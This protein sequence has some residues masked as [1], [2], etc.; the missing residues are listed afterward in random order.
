[1][2]KTAVSYR[3][4]LF[5]SIVFL[6]SA[7]AA[8]AQSI[9]NYSFSQS[10][11][12]YI[13][14]TGATNAT[15]LVGSLDDGLYQNIPI[16]FDFW[17]MGNRFTSISAG[18]NGFLSF[19]LINTGDN[20]HV[21]NNLAT[22][23]QRNVLAPLWDDLALNTTTAVSYFLT[24]AVGSRTFTIQYTNVKWRF[25]AAVNM[26]F[27]VRLY[28]ANGEIEYNYSPPNATAA[29]AAS[30]SIGISAANG[31]F[32][33]LNATTNTAAASSAAETTTLS[34]KPA[35]NQRYSFIPVSPN[36][37]T[38]AVYSAIS[39]TSMTLNWTD[40]ANDN[41]YVIYRSTDGTNYN[42]ELTT[43][44]NANSYTATNL[45][46]NTTYYW[47][48]Y[49]LR[50]SLSNGFLQFPAQSTSFL[51]AYPFTGNAN[52]VGGSNNNGT[53]QGTNGGAASLTNDRY[54]S[55]N[56]AYQFD[57]I[58]DNITTT[59]AMAGPQVFSISI[60]FRTS[61]AG[62]KLIGFGGNQ[63]GSSGSYDRHIYMDNAGKVYFGVYPGQTKTLNSSASLN[64]NV[65]HNAIATLSS[66]GMKLYI[67]GVLQG[68]DATVT[69]AQ[70]YTGYWRIGY[71]NTNGWPSTPTN[72]YF[73]GALDD[74]Q[75]TNYE[76]SN[77]EIASLS[78][79]AYR[80]Y[81]YTLPVTL[82][83][84]S[85]VS[86]TQTN[87]PYLI[88]I[89]DD[90][91]KQVGSCDLTVSNPVFGKVTS[92]VGNDIAFTDE[93]GAALSFDVEQY[94][95]AT[96]SLLAWVKLPYVSSTINKK[97]NILIGNPSATANNSS[98]TWSTDYK[99]VFHFKES[100]YSGTTTDATSTA[101]VGT[102]VGMTSA[103]LV[104]TGKVGNA[105][106]YNGSTQQINVAANAVYAI[107]G[108]AYT[109]SA[110]IN[111]GST[112]PDQKVVTNQEI[113][114][115]ADVVP[116]DP[117][118]GGYKIGLYNL[119]PESENRVA[120]GITYSNRQTY[121][122]VAGNAT[123]LA[124]GSWYYVQ[125]VFYGNIVVT[126]VN[127]VERQRRVN[128]IAASTGRNL[129]IGVGEGGNK[130][131][132]N[133]LIDEVRVSDVAKSTSWLLTE[134]QNQNSPGS[135][136]K[137]TV[138][139][140]LSV[141][142]T[143]PGLIYSFTGVTSSFPGTSWTNTITN[144]TGAPTGNFATVIIPAGKSPIL[145]AAQSVYAI[146]IASGSTLAL[147]GN[148]L[149]VACNVYNNGQILNAA[150]S[151]L[152]FNGSL[153]P[154]QEYFGTSTV[155]TVDNLTINNTHPSAVGIININAGSKLDI[156]KLVSISKGILNT[157]L[158]GSGAL[159]LKSTA[160]TNANIGPLVSGT[161]NVTGTI[162]IESYFTGGVNGTAIQNFNRGTRLVSSP[163]NDASLTNKT[164]KQLQGT[165]IITGA[166]GGGF[167]IGN[168]Q[169][170]YATTIT[171]FNEVPV[172]QS[173]PALTN[174]NNS[175]PPGDGFFL[176]YR[177]DRTTNYALSG[178]FGTGSK[179]DAGSPTGQI[180]A[181]PE[182]VTATYVGPIN[183]FDISR[184]L[185]YTANGADAYNGYNVV[186]NP[187]PSTISFQQL[188]ADNT[189]RID[190]FAIIIKPGGIQATTSAGVYTNWGTIADQ[191]RI[192]TGQGFYVRAKSTANGTGLVFKET[193]KLS[194]ISSPPK[195]LALPQSG[196]SQTRL[197]GAPTDVDL[198][199][200][201]V[202]PVMRLELS[203]ELDKDEIAL[204]FE[205]GNS[206][207]YAG[208]DALH[209]TNPIIEL[210]SVSEDNQNLAINF[211]PEVKDIKTVRLFLNNSETGKV[212]LRFTDLSPVY[213]YKVF[214]QDN[215]LGTKTDVMANKEITLD[216][217]KLKPQTYGADR[218]VLIF[219]PETQP[220]KLI[221]ISATKLTGAATV[222]WTVQNEKSSTSY[223][224][225]KSTDNLS[226]TELG[227]I[228]GSFAGSSLGSYSK[229][230]GKLN[231]LN[232]YRVKQIE[233]SGRIT[234]SD[235][236]SVALSDNELSGDSF[237]VYPTVVENEINILLN[238][239]ASQEKINVAIYDLLGKRVYTGSGIKHVVGQ[240]PTGIYIITVSDASNG[241]Q[242]GK[243]KFIKR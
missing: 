39:T 8:S 106:T 194:T 38:S 161:S 100:A 142:S 9:N 110:W 83:T 80:N 160:T 40:V 30:A 127:G 77:A 176:F 21:T 105:Y 20:Y 153:N 213:A 226:F 36:L 219:E 166:S 42:I 65:W 139:A 13:A 156:L 223:V 118:K 233:S 187:Y 116:N 228:A 119:I 137:G 117:R 115:A 103:N 58:D 66:S 216:I 87:F 50:E 210:A 188:Y 208:P 114:S 234:Y 232:Y 168:S 207:K 98:T 35:V 93:F 243:S 90:N 147:S 84:T 204:V 12:T 227:T 197:M 146:S 224:L 181:T 185:S 125:S 163:I 18:T 238:K 88:S 17:Y 221:A 201:E 193:Q 91:L 113:E 149:N 206:T 239:G 47:R 37:P 6:F 164:Y 3:I 70:V 175:A 165:M 202:R 170:P 215:F 34:V 92:P 158:I 72:W 177:G 162:N 99:A 57:G 140:N 189:A 53:V 231:D 95:P 173:F 97:I 68:T 200:K 60:W 27:Q 4:R 205:N 73:T 130:Y 46:P 107:T 222:K 104:T 198:T 122:N 45:N 2:N 145:S 85:I 81:G 150:N 19:D 128:S 242:I 82:N 86:G 199:S 151:T 10:S 69:S 44:A 74:I 211:L 121:P 143:Y 51:F 225:E 230:D 179:I 184:T 155:S 61:V 5:L 31:I 16:G 133:G 159:T 59:T 75:V 229:S 78:S 157:S 62:G 29:S 120:G 134:Y 96:G 89:T 235:V 28:E 94:V 241:L 7:I 124:I 23:L 76:L 64:D 218:L 171:K 55:V 217:D 178:G 236:V 192:Q 203:N 22:S 196:L 41:G 111:V 131:W 79:T 152:N 1:M 174:I 54:G 63:S 109:I 56:S 126:Y 132:F 141:A 190:D 237:K 102:T 172:T 182:N 32:Q 101:L 14:L 214:L 52:D 108:P 26:A 48:I 43:A 33:S 195:F 186:G 15:G 167:D 11:S 154:T 67:D 138:A 144:V 209:G 212:T 24:G 169:R 112:A 123:T 136:T 148:T 25:D 180:Y 129:F 240:L 191:G 183:A 71:D 220:Y 49:T 135:L